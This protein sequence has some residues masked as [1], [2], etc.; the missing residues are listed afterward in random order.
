MPF[1]EFDRQKRQM[2]RCGFKEYLA[3]QFPAVWYVTFNFN[4]YGR[5]L[6][7]ASHD[8][9]F[10]WKIMSRTLLGARYAK[11]REGIQMCGVFEHINRNIH[12]HALVGLPLLRRTV[13]FSL[14]AQLTFVKRVRLGG[15]LDVQLIEDPASK[16]RIADYM[17]KHMLSDETI[18]N[19]F[20]WPDASFSLPRPTQD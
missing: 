9:R 17:T 16:C 1:V 3:H 12:C 6:S 11:K 20:L 5:S 18:E 8:I 10:W 13:D 7:A 14:L 4:H 15:Q 2:Y 19:W